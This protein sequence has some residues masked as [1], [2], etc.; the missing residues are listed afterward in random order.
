MPADHFQVLYGSI[1]ANH[2]FQTNTSLD[3]SHLGQG[4]IL[5]GGVENPFGL[6]HLAADANALGGGC[7]GRWGRGWSTGAQTADD[8]TQHSTCTSS[9]H[10]ARNTSHY[11]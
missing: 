7:L 4:R 3:T 5:R 1:L 11:T 10:S 9:R 6:F 2:G 8:T